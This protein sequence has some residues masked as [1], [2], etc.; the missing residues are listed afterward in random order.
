MAA[1]FFILITITGQCW[2]G[3]QGST[4]AGRMPGTAWHPPYDYLENGY[5]LA[6]C[7][8]PTEP[9]EHQRCLLL[10][11]METD[12]EMFG[13][14][15]KPSCASKSIS[16]KDLLDI[17]GLRPVLWFHAYIFRSPQACT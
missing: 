4:Q 8:R 13:E 12:R 9:A 3:S 1:V 7:L 11:R 10:L 16:L 2:E 15:S 6:G 17:E 14:T 5:S